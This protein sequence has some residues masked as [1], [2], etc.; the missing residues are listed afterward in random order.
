MRYH[1]TLT[2]DQDNDMLIEFSLASFNDDGAWN[3][4]DDNHIA[5][6]IKDLRFVIDEYERRQGFV[7]GE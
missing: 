7:R 1:L 2:N 4:D 6:I 3:I 5:C